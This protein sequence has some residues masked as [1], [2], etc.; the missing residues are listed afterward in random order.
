MNAECRH[1]PAVHDWLAGEMPPD[2][3]TAFELHLASCAECSVDSLH[4]EHLP[5]RPDRVS[6]RQTCSVLRA[7]PA[8]SGSCVRV[9][10]VIAL[11]LFLFA[12]KEGRLP[13]AHDEEER[14]LQCRW[15][16]LLDRL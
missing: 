1:L 15:L 9:E 11:F 2:E 10:A 12:M 8:I 3:A 4:R 5:T 14:F 6:G 7:L 13:K 16:W